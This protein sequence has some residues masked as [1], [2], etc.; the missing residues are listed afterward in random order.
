MVYPL[1]VEDK[2]LMEKLRE[3]QIYT[4]RWWNSVLQTVE[5]DSF[6]AFLSTYMLPL[7]IDQRYNNNDI[8][9]VNK[10]VAEN[11]ENQC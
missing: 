11:V 4:G 9:I 10:I 8:L 5:D 7:P 6:E 3:K 2:Y 1:V